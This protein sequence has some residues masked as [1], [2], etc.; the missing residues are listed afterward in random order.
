MPIKL[1][2][3]PNLDEAA[4]RREAAKTQRV[5]ESA[6]KQAGSQ[7]G[8]QFTGGL[9]SAQTDV[10]KMG[11]SFAQMYDKAADAAGKLRV[12]ETKLKEL[13]EKGV[14]GSKLVAQVE[15]EDA[16]RRAEARSVR[17]TAAAYKELQSAQRGT[18]AGSGGGLSAMMR[19]PSGGS[20][21]FSSFGKDAAAG[22]SKSFSSAFKGG[23][24]GGMVGTAVMGIFS[25]IAGPISRVAS[26]LGKEFAGAFMASMK[27][28]IDFQRIQ[29]EFQGVTKSNPAQ[30]ARATGKARE[31]GG[32]PTMPGVSAAGAMS[33]ITALTKGGF[34]A[35]QAMD[36]AR[37]RWSWRRRRRLRARM[38]PRF[39]PTTSTCSG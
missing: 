30:M 10:A 15:R 29:N 36:G 3:K 19:P 20:G 37:G 25:N 14:T 7:F 16:A 33:T 39:C 21:L 35:Q 31:L 2:I 24:V 34:T 11:R 18:S 1:D 23:A 13:R 8:K 5:F 32:D 6:G 4:A 17:E 22:F 38:P 26:S 28:G 9:Q 12:E 27:T